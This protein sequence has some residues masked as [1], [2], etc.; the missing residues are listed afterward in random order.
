MF[1]KKIYFQNIPAE[2][3]QYRTKVDIDPIGRDEKTNSGTEN[4]GYN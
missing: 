4:K 3:K 2:Y 1:K